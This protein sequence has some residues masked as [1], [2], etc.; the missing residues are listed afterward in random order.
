[1]FCRR[2]SNESRLLDKI[3]QICGEDCEIYYEDWSWT[4]VRWDGCDPM[5]TKG[6]RDLVRKKFTVE[7]VDEFN[8]SKMCSSCHKPLEYYINRHRKYSR[9]RMFLL[10]ERCTSGS[11]KCIRFVDR[12]YNFAKCPWIPLLFGVTFTASLALLGEY[13]SSA[14]VCSF[15]SA[16]LTTSSSVKLLLFQI[17]YN[18]HSPLPW[19]QNNEWDVSEFCLANFFPGALYS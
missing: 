11:S 3:A 7:P 9:S 13:L 6:M 14:K 1:M 10:S 2:K 5:P 8:M 17:P 4:A 12:D 16:W 18:W 15:S 19:V